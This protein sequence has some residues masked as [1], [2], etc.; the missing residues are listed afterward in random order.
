MSDA[1]YVVQKVDWFQLRTPEGKAIMVMVAALPNGFHT[2]VPVEV[3]MRLAAHGMMALAASA[4]DA[5]TQ[6]Q[7]TLAGKG[8]EEIF[9][10]DHE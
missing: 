2:A 4:E 7:T 5:L 1:T 3:S 10:H 9:P 6:L 8:P